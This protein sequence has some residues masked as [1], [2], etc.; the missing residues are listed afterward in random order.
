MQME[1]DDML[2]N[3]LIQRDVLHHKQSIWFKQISAI[4]CDEIINDLADVVASYVP[5]HRVTPH[6]TCHYFTIFGETQGPQWIMTKFSS[7]CTL[8][9][10]QYL[11]DKQHGEVHKWKQVNNMWHL[12]RR[13][14]YHIGRL[15]GT[16]THWDIETGVKIYQGSF[17][18]DLPHGVSMYWDNHGTKLTLST[19]REGKLHG[20]QKEW[21]R[22]GQLSSEFTYSN[23]KKNG[24]ERRWNQKGVLVLEREWVD[25][26]IVST[27]LESF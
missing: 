23:R 24:T 2:L 16:T 15:H 11:N 17:C 19:Y 6:K 7:S 9:R 27:L 4:L 25:D 18:R 26:V 5:D 21:F 3:R 13:Y 1:R 8:S 12:M 20:V 14:M 10:V 22:N